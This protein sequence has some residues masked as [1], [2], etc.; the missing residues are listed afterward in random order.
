MIDP[1]KES[2]ISE[3][4]DQSQ[5]EDSHE[6]KDEK[7]DSAFE[8]SESEAETRDP[9]RRYQNEIAS[10][11]ELPL[12]VP[13]EQVVYKTVDH[14]SPIFTGA[15]KINGQLLHAVDG[16]R[17]TKRDSGTISPSL[18]VELL[19]R[20]AKSARYDEADG[21]KLPVSLKKSNE[22]IDQKLKETLEQMF[23]DDDDLALSED[24]DEMRGAVRP[25]TLLSD[26]DHKP[27]ANPP[28]IVDLGSMWTRIGMSSE[29]DP[30]IVQ[31]T[32][33]GELRKT[34]TNKQQTYYG[35]DVVSRSGK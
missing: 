19:E 35:Q 3:I 22:K 33:I 11:T 13:L 34:L 12:E 32:M 7:K 17:D 27:S 10:V 25:A 8:T 26:F 28:L 15:E 30:T 2:N 1:Q 6:G 31:R 21:T 29:Q 20:E 4:L 24:E 23:D 14:H 9:P 5:F 18:S 16:T